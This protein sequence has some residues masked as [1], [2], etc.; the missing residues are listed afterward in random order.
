MTGDCGFVGSW[1]VDNLTEKGHICFFSD[2]VAS[3]Q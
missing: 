2:F 3:L 1:L